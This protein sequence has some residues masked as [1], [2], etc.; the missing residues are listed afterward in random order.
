MLEWVTGQE[1]SASRQT[2]RSHADRQSAIRTG[3]SSTHNQSH[4]LLQQQTRPELDPG[5]TLL[6]PEELW[7]ILRLFSHPYLSHPHPANSQTE[8]QTGRGPQGLFTGRE[9]PSL[10]PQP[11]PG[12]LP[13][14]FLQAGPLGWIRGLILPLSGPSS[15][16]E[17][18]FPQAI[19][20]LIF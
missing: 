14:T 2:D 10:L 20:C 9:R 1:N 13:V 17:N 5:P 18:S 19:K 11:S 3:R 15:F 16:L 7:V 8:K 12:S 6:L 4:F